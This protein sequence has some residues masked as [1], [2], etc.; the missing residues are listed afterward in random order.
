MQMGFARGCVCDVENTPS[1]PMHACTCR[2]LDPCMSS[3]FI[4]QYCVSQVVRFCL[5]TAQSKLKDNRER[6]KKG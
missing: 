6:F 4:L 5:K 2:S 3:F 1:V